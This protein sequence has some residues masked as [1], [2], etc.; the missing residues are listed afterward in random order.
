MHKRLRMSDPLEEIPRL[1]Q[2]GKPNPRFLIYDFLVQSLEE[3]WSWDLGKFLR[4]L[5][6]ENCGG[7]DQGWAKSEANAY[8]RKMERKWKDRP[9]LIQDRI[10]RMIH[11][12]QAESAWKKGVSC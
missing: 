1:L 10:A 7:F 3:G 11:E 8:L 4:K 6:A 9:S 5:C 12:M 2:D